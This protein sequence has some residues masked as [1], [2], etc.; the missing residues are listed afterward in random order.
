MKTGCFKYYKE[1]NGVAICLRPPVSWNGERFKL[2][3]PPLKT[4]FA[5]K[6]NKISQEQYE[7]EYRNEVLYKLNAFEIYEKFKNKVLLCWEEP[8][9]DENGKVI[10]L[11]NGFCH[12]HI[13]SKWI[14]EN[15]SIE[16]NEWKQNEKHIYTK[17][18]F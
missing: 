5:I 2:L 17:K 8:I 6:N 11:G 3:A 12:R 18:L 15:T 14:T 16:V 1:H 9:F 10:N 13:V 7:Y 4:F